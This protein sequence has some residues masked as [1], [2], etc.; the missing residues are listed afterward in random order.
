MI[1]QHLVI[2]DFHVGATFQFRTF[3]TSLFL[4]DRSKKD[5][6]CRFYRD[7]LRKVLYMFQNSQIIFQGNKISENKVIPIH[8]NAC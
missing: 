6:A 3:C 8:Q 7:P 5:G 2:Q 1:I 4:I